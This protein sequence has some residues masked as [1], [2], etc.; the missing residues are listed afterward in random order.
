MPRHQKYRDTFSQTDRWW[1][2][3]LTFLRHWREIPSTCGL[4]SALLHLLGHSTT[5]Y[6]GRLLYCFDSLPSSS[7][8]GRSSSRL[9]RRARLALKRSDSASMQSAIALASPLRWASHGVYIIPFK[10]YYRSNGI[11]Q[12]SRWRLLVQ[13][14]TRYRGKQA[15]KSSLQV[16]F[17]QCVHGVRI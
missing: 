5:S 10:S 16:Q 14:E 3:N 1:A 17:F 4:K 8:L 2:D 6:I 9:K 11:S 15:T 12:V 7:W 13:H